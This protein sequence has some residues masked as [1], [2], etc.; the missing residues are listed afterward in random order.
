MQLSPHF[1]LEEFACHDG[2][3][4]P[5]HAHQALRELCR[6]YLEPLRS[7]YG[8]T[9]IISGYRTPEWNRAVGGAVRSY[10]VYRRGRRGVAADVRCARGTPLRWAELVD[11]LGAGGVSSEEAHLHVDTR[12]RRARW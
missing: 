10:H 11:D 3:P 2:T 1:R 9:T 5:E 8:A 7:R 4:V 12:P 6:E